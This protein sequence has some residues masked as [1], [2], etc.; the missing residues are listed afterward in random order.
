MLRCLSR[1]DEW[2][3]ASR[4]LKLN[5]TNVAI[6]KTLQAQASAANASAASSSKSHKAGGAGTGKDTGGTG[7]GARAGARKDGMRGTKRGREE[8]GLR[9]I[10]FF[11]AFFMLNICTGW[12]RT[13]ATR[14][15]I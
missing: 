10:P 12:N 6:Q 1:W 13:R 2:V 9:L 4:L 3:P 14:S 11:F 15:Q 5:D 8:V 7:A